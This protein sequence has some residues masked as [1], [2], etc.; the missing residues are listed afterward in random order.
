MSM[1]GMHD[2]TCEPCHREHTC[3]C[4]C[5]CPD[6]MTAR[7]VYPPPPIVPYDQTQARYGEGIDITLPEGERI[8]SPDHVRAM[9]FASGMKFREMVRKAYEEADANDKKNGAKS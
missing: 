6:H 8:L 3:T 9:G 5:H 7:P 1:M 4:K 2:M